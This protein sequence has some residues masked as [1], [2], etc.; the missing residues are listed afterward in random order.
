M[1]GRLKKGFMAV[2]GAV[3]MMS[4]ITTTEVLAEDMPKFKI[5]GFVDASFYD[6]EYATSS[7]TL[8]EVEIDIKGTLSE[9]L[10]LRADLNYREV[11]TDSDSDGIEDLTSDEI[12]EQGYLTYAADLGGTN[13]DLTFG[14]FNIPM[15]FELLDPV[16]MYQYSHS[17][18][19]NYGIPT[20]V[21]GAMV[22]SKLTEML[23]LSLYY[24]NG[25]DINS[26][27]N[28]SKTVGG[29]FGITP[30][31]GINFG[32]SAISGKEQD[33]GTAGEDDTRTV[34][35]VDFTITAI[36]K[37]T[38]G[39]EF[40][41]GEEENLGLVAGT[42]AEWTAY[43]LMANYQLNDTCSLTLRYDNF[44]DEDGTRLDAVE[45]RKSY[46]VAALHSLGDGAGLLFEYRLDD[47]DQKV[48]NGST[49]DSKQSFAVEFTYSF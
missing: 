30:A 8:D 40:N 38:I 43:M 5:S 1:T 44:D 2:M 22:S 11:D 15:G 23:D 47:S 12:F 3:I 9:K 16:D 28:N 33:A 35:D 6:E 24:V 10:T 27:N 13:V 49:E 31:E 41:T 21:T 45:E 39:G 32:L 34:F 20:N 26:D 42:D 36:D 17:L 25:W 18:I 4:G 7:F 46:T 37:L 14:K 19:F 48:F 29:R